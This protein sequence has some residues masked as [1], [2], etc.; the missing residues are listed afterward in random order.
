MRLRGTSVGCPTLWSPKLVVPV[1][2][3][4]LIA[5]RGGIAALTKL[6]DRA[7]AAAVFRAPAGYGKTTL[8]ANW[9]RC[10]P[11]HGEPVAWV[12]IDRADDDGDVLSDHILAAV[13]DALGG[14]E[15]AAEQGPAARRLT[16][17]IAELTADR[18]RRTWL[19]LDSVERL[20]SAESLR[21]LEE[22]LARIPERLRVVV[23]TRPTELADRLADRLADLSHIRV[24]ADDLT[25]TAAETT[26]FLRRHGLCL[27][28]G[29]T[30]RLMNLTEGWPAGIRLAAIIL[31]N[32]SGTVAELGN[33]L[34]VDRA[35]T[36]Y[37]TIEVLDDL[38]AKQLHLLLCTC[39]PDE[40]DAG[41][42]TALSGL[43]DAPALLADL[44]RTGFLIR[45][46]GGHTYRQHRF[47][48]AHLLAW[49][50][51]RFPKLLEQR[52][53]R[54]AR[55]FIGKGQLVSAAEHAR[56]SG[57][58]DLSAGIL[59]LYGP[60]LLLRGKMSLIRDVA[61]RLPPES[62]ARPEIGL[63]VALAE[64]MT[65]DRTGAELRLAGLAE[66]LS[67]NKNSRTAA[68]ETIVR[69][70]WTR[71][72]DR[73]V[74][75]KN[76]LDALVP[77]AGGQWLPTLAL[78]NRGTISFWLG[79]YAAARDDLERTLATATKQDY[80][81]AVL[82]S[83]S[84]L[85]GIASAEG[86]FPQMRETAERAIEFAKDRSL[87]SACCFAYACE[88]WAAYQSMDWERALPAMDLA[89][90]AV[91]QTGD[92][93][94]ETIV[95]SLKEFIEYERGTDP[96]A[97]MV[98]LRAHWNGLVTADPVQPSLIAY[99]AA[100]EQRMALRLGRADWAAETPRR[101]AAWLGQSGD[102]LLMQARMH[103]HHGQ[104]GAARALLDRVNRKTVRSVVVT[105]LIDAHLLSATLALRADDHARAEREFTAAVEIAEPRRALRSFVDGGDEIRELA[106][107]QAGRMGRLNDFVASLRDAFSASDKDIVALTPREVE[108]LRELPSLAT[109]EEIAAS[110]YVSVNT[111]KTHLRHIYHKLGVRSRR[112]AV[113]TARGRGLL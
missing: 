3:R 112:E 36:D 29:Q 54:A 90:A 88:V 106:V 53:E 4:D 66:A 64:I 84:Y 82:H 102:V 10:R 85:G 30:A 81:Y 59:A 42:A 95:L 37:V 24:E 65:G 25:L 28:A 108:L 103:V 71:K 99:E 44:A 14:E 38:T 61:G 69:T 7:A 68:L 6:R 50:R 22:L 60:E 23:C 105:T 98:R 13:A 72:I 9:M 110:R 2:S 73:V 97:A 91:D 1:A 15:T 94:V 101:A 32:S 39:V 70:H 111:V 77:A 19:V 107:A 43:K 113:A 45:H 80:D 75:E 87:R 96:Y 16:E 34:G 35:V 18:P 49:Q 67:H 63:I 31:S 5:T 58:T 17:K 92:R 21:V 20:R 46:D 100:I 33:R 89:L 76:A 86:D 52:H 40:F 27:D 74:A 51:W 93:I 55:W 48:R 26:P 104:V 78:L 11:A 57:D 47:V 62:L 8:V 83:L 41:L 56:A 12:S 109:V 79:D